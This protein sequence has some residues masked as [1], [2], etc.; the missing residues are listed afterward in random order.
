MKK[1]IFKKKIFALIE[2]MRQCLMAL[3]A[4]LVGYAV[5]REEITQLL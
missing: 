4:I 3:I 1:E 2:L 5:S